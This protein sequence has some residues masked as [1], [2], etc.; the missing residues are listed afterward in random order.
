MDGDR[1][2]PTCLIG[3]LENSQVRATLRSTLVSSTESDGRLAVSQCDS[4]GPCDSARA[5]SV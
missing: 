2:S 1:V 3:S 4:T 5:I